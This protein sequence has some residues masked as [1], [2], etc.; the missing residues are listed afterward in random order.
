MMTFISTFTRRLSWGALPLL[1]VALVW[2]G[3]DNEELLTPEPEAGDIFARYVAI[4][5]SI[6]AGYQ[7]DGINANTQADSYANLVAQQMGT[8]F[9]LPR[10]V[11]PGCPPPLT[12][13][14]PPERLGGENAPRCRLRS[15]P[16]PTVVNNVAVPGA[17]VIDVL[18]NT[19]A[20]SNA[21]SLTTFIL[22]GRTQIEAVREAQ[23]TFVSAWIGNN[24][25]L[26][27]ALAGNTD[28]ITPM[29]DFESR[30]TDM[31]DDLD[32]M[33]DL[34][35]GV[36]IGVADVTFVP[37]LIPGA[38]YWTLSQNPIVQQFLPDNFIVASNC[39]EARDLVPFAY[40]QQLIGQ[41]EAN[42][43]LDIALDCTASTGVLTSD[44]LETLQTTVAEYNNFIAQQADSRGYAFVNPNDLF[45]EFEDQI[46]TTPDLQS[47][48]PFGPYFSLDGVHP[49]SLAHTL[50]ASAVINAINTEY[51][52][53]IPNVPNA[54][55]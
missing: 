12:T 45:T 14:F 39:E 6:T 13:F 52:T 22:G 41:A 49:S 53:S 17:E 7:S 24:D 26:G 36:L 31:L 2:T 38:F 34:E 55:Q 47:D 8:T 16:I 51:G 44:E 15:T 5:N 10:L 35:G 9:N 18:S 28:L 27:A 11:P 23:P 50:I 33:E 46:P 25:V 30:Y 21:N 43:E 29:S 32:A 19:D 48:Q 3:C 37:N 20:A 40:V 54:G 42:P 4:G 1:F